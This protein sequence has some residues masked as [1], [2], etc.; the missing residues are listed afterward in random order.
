MYFRS[1]MTAIVLYNYVAFQCFFHP[2]MTAIVLYNYVAF[3]CLNVASLELEI[4]CKLSIYTVLLP[5]DTAPIDNIT[6]LLVAYPI[7][8]KLFKPF[9][10]KPV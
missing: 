8:H 9:N 10:S 7:K 4:K 2:L 5:Y 6:P 3:Q 1:L